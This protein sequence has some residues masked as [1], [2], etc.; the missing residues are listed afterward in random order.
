MEALIT[1]YN[2]FAVSLYKTLIEHTDKNIFFSPMS[3]ASALTMILPG[4]NGNTE[5]QMANVLNFRKPSGK[6]GCN[7]KTSDAIQIQN[8][9]EVFEE[10]SSSINQPSSSYTLKMANRVFSEKS[11][12]IIQQYTKV[13]EKYFQAEM[14]A[15]DFLQAVEKSRKS[16]NTWV[17]KQT[18]GKIKDILVP[19]SI[20]SLTKLVLVNAIYFKGSWENKFP[21]ENTEQKPFKMSKIKSKPVPMMFQ[22]S[23]FN[24]FY[25]EELETKVLEL[26]Y[27]NNELSMVILLPD[28]IKDNSTGLEQLEKKLSY[29]NLKNWTNA[30]MMDKSEVEIDLPRIILEENYD[31]K[32]YLTEMGLG[33][34]FS[35]D[36]ADLTGISEQGNLHVSEIFHK[37]FVE[38][39]EEGTEAAAA[40]AGVVVARM[41]PIAEVFRAD[42][43]FLFFIKHKPTNAILF[44]GKFC[45]P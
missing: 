26:P 20:D 17:E 44:L 32:S 15:V 25:I 31:L 19:G 2:T 35:A 29:D 3:I 45:S 8:V 18:D 16:I 24:I 33:D 5:F 37:A 11:F 10:F 34:L 27:V 40:T 1:S 9:P 42:H 41:R 30:D 38:I 28:E 12:N 36:K 23:K 13:L 21:E 7:S 43:P 6:Q 39:N 4:T 22:R 14:Q